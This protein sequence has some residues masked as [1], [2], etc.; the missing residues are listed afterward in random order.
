[1]RA[2][3]TSPTSAGNLAASQYAES[4]TAMS[5]SATDYGGGNPNFHLAV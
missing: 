5:G 2:C 1:V 4:A 3:A